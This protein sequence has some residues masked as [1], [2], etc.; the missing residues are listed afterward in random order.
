MEQKD[1][2]VSVELAYRIADMLNQEIK[3]QGEIKLN[4]KTIWKGFLHQMANE[5][6]LYLIALMEELGDQQPWLIKP[7]DERVLREARRT[8][9][10]F[11]PYYDR[12]LDMRNRHLNHKK[13]EWQLIMTVRE[14]WN[15]ACDIHLP[16]K[17]SSKTVQDLSEIFEVQE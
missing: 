6:W 16:N 12:V 13:L 17:D 4:N 11:S 1:I 15:R 2:E 8:I 10:K 7:W 5:D 14:V 9:E 3:K